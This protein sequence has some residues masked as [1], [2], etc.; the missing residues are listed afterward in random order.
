LWGNQQ[1][2]LLLTTPEVRSVD[3]HLTGVLEMMLSSNES[4][5]A[6]AAARH[7]HVAASTITRNPERRALLAKYVSDQ[8]RLRDIMISA[9]KMS[10]EKLVQQVAS[11]DR[12][13]SELERRLQILTASHKAMLLAIGEAGGMAAWQRFFASYESIRMELHGLQPIR[14]T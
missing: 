1:G 13:I 7:L 3:E 14:H 2:G 4:I 9:D 8:K 5:T 10:K 11:R 6:R 12:R